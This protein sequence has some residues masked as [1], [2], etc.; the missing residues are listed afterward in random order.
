MAITKDYKVEWS[1]IKT[2]YDSLNAQRTRFQ[3]VGGPAPVTVPARKGEKVNASDINTLD[4]LINAMQSVTQ[5]GTDAVTGITRPATSNLIQPGDFKTKMEAAINRMAQD[6][7][8][9]SDNRGFSFFTSDRSFGF[10]YSCSFGFFTTDR[11]FQF[12]TTDRGFSF[13]TSD[14]SFGF[15]TRNDT[16]GFS[17]PVFNH[18]FSGGYYC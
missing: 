18:Y 6:C 1:D 14:R 5:I 3:T 10:F 16:F 12:Y 11:T 17:T 4:D 7:P 9:F 13:F 8:H 2:I 15:N